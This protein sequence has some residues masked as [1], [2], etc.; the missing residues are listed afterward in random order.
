MSQYVIDLP[1]SLLEQ[2]SKF[3]EQEKISVNKLFVSLIYE[4]LSALL[5]SQDLLKE[6]A[7]HADIEACRAILA[8]VPDNPIDDLDKI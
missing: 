6:R 8:K 4:K 3:A 5:E 2:A 7:K 1:D